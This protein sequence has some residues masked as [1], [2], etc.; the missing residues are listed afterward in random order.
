MLPLQQQRPLIGDGLR[1]RGDRGMGDKFFS[2]HA[3]LPVGKGPYWSRRL[4]CRPCLPQR[5]ASIMCGRFDGSSPLR[6]AT[7][8]ISE[9]NLDLTRQI[10]RP[11][12]YKRFG[13]PQGSPKRVQIIIFFNHRGNRL[14]SSRKGEEA[15]RKRRVALQDQTLRT[16]P[17]RFVCATAQPQLSGQI[18]G[19]KLG[20]AT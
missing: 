14:P 4:W 7:R 1:L 6:A 15:N 20:V 13:G 2:M 11:R 9:G 3:P 18:F 19:D 5:P 12:S 16:T 17:D 8:Q 10:A